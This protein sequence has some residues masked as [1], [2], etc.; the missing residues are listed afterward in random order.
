MEGRPSSSTARISSETRRGVI[1]I[2]HRLVTGG[3]AG[4]GEALAGDGHEGPV[5]AARVQRQFEHAEGG[6]VAHLA[7]GGVGVGGFVPKEVRL[8]PPVPTTNWRMPRALSRTPLA[9][10]GAKRS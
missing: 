5:V 2:L 10:C 8:R 3:G 1:R 4:V 6:V 7:V 9:F